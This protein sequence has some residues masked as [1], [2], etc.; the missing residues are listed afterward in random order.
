MPAVVITHGCSGISSSQVA[1]ARQLN[2][3][4]IATLMVQSFA[5]R[6]IIEL[7][8]GRSSLNIAS[9]IVDAYRALDEL[10]AHP[11]ID[12]ERVAILGFS[13]GGRTALWTSQVRLHERYGTPGR[14]FA[15][16]L[17]FYPTGCFMQLEG[18]EQ[19]T[20]APIRIFHGTADDWTPLEQCA[21]YIERLHQSGKGAELFAYPDALHGFDN[22]YVTGTNP[23]SDAV[24]PRNCTF[25]E[26][27]GRLIDLATGGEASVNSPCVVR[28][29]TV[30]YNAAAHERS[31]RDVEAFLRS[32]FRLP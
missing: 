17:A 26:R 31:A 13:F 12:P 15:A 29:V 7:C 1:W 2:D 23:I 25:V 28:G 10:A 16:H 20:G 6:E 32:V 8:S 3:L 9:V 5:G 30:G 11:R 14:A 21:A 22:G 27:D 19:V 18:E 24:S 4:G